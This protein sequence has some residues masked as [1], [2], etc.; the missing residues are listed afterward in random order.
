MPCLCS[1]TNESENN[2]QQQT[3]DTEN[4]SVRPVWYGYVQLGLILI[5]VAIALYFARAPGRVQLDMAAGQAA[6][7]SRPVVNVILPAPTEQALTV[8]L[9][10]TVRAYDQVAVR[11]EVGR[12]GGLGFARICQR[13]VDCGKR[14]L[15]QD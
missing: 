1:V 10:G 5:V 3:N 11:S 12:T 6:G 9:T 7:E 14:D 8:K 15:R 13:R 2:M 4:R